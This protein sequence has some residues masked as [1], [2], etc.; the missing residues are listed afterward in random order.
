MSANP[1]DILKAIQ[2]LKAGKLVGMPTETVY[3]L[4]GDAGNSK[5]VA[6][7]YA[8]KNRPSFNP[9]I[10][11]IASLEMAREQ[12][13]FGD[14]ALE[15]AETFWPGPMTLVLPVRPSNTVCDLARAG[16]MTQAIR[17]PNHEVAQ[18]LI[19]GFGSSLVA[20]SANKSGRISPTK[21]RHVAEEF[22]CELDMVLDGGDAVLGLESTVLAVLDGRVTLL[23]PGSL[24][25]E[26][27]ENLIGPIQSSLHDDKAPK[28]PG[29]LSRH[30]APNAKL[31]L[32]AKA[33]KPDE[34]Y[35]GFGPDEGVSTLNLSETANLR[36]AASN[37]Y[38][39]LRML[40]E[41]YSAI[42]VAPIPEKGLG[43]A[44]NDRLRRACVS[45]E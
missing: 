43:E 16:L 10:A 28:S 5:S 40:D 3:G 22:G 31:R 30:Y 35:L 24:P 41:A 36:E 8:L 27:I 21:P 6:A 34:A 17:W 2:L 42:A 26:E 9:L 15:L 11:H 25:R 38:A 7:I 4:A 45:A 37:L 23:R 14:L 39:M 13:E 1:S 12:A 19:E 18:K 44:I 20:P 29:M 33:A 32:N